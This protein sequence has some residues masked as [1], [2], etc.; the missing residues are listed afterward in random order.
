M[1]HP[2]SPRRPSGGP[3]DS[4][5]TKPTLFG[6]RRFG[7]ARSAPKR[8]LL[9]RSEI[10]ADS[11]CD[12]G[13]SWPVRGDAGPVGRPHGGEASP[14]AVCTAD[15]SGSR[16]GCGLDLLPIGGRNHQVERGARI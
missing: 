8:A 14:A 2:S 3:C 11:P 7:W 12:G 9:T 1:A 13:Y 5:R 16:E 4:S 15:E 10:F 6:E